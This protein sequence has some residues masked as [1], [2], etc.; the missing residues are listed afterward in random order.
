M[1]D[2]STLS[3]MK[4]SESRRRGVLRLRQ[5]LQRVYLS[6]KVWLSGTLRSLHHDRPQRNL[7]RFTR[8]T[9]TLRAHK[10]CSNDSPE[11]AEDKDEEATGVAYTLT[12]AR[13]Y[14]PHIAGRREP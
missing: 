13:S 1:T 14:F 12:N 2:T 10:S 4:Q 8:A 5:S 3:G 11:C 6:A 9:S 7:Q